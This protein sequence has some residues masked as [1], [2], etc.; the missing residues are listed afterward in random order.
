MAEFIIRA[1]NKGGS[2]SHVVRAKTWLAAWKKYEQSPTGRAVD[3]DKVEIYDV[4]KD[5]SVGFVK[6]YVLK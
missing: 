1:F 3:A 4:D 5:G 6:C 2:F